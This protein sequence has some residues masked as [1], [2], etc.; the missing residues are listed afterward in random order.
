MCRMVMKSREKK[1]LY[2]CEFLLGKE[3][4][5]IIVQ[6]HEGDEGLR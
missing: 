3:N 4:V 1:K 6:T 2:G 5:E